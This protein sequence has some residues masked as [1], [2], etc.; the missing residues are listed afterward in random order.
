M[1][2]KQGIKTGLIL[3]LALLLFGSCKEEELY[4]INEFTKLSCNFNDEE[5]PNGQSLTAYSAESLVYDAK[6][7]SVAETR[8]CN[9]GELSG[10]FEFASCVEEPPANCSFDNQ[11]VLHEDYVEAFQLSAVEWNQSCNDY[12]KIRTCDNGTLSEADY[13]FPSCTATEPL[14]CTFESQTVLHGA[15]VEAY[16]LSSVP[17]NE[18]CSS[19]RETRSCENG[20]LSGQGFTFSSCEQVT[21]D[22]CTFE[23]QT[24]LHGA[25]VEAYQLSSVPWNETCSSYRE[26]RSCENGVLS[27]QG[28]AFS[29]CEQVAPDN[30]S[31]NDQ[32]VEHQSSVTAWQ[33]SSVP[34][35][36]SC[37]SQERI[38][39]NGQLSGS[40]TF[41]SCATAAP[42]NCSAADYGQFVQH[43][44]SEQF[45]QTATV[46][47]GSSCQ[48][49][50]RFCNNGTLSGSYTFASCSV[51][52][53]SGC[54][55]SDGG[56]TAH[57]PN[58][59][60]TLYNTASS[61]WPAT[62]EAHVSSSVTCNNGD[63]SPVSLAAYSYQSC[64]NGTPQSCT[65][66]T[67]GGGSSTI[68]HDASATAY[69]AQSV[70]F[71]TD[72]GC[73]SVKVE[74]QC[75]DSDFVNPNDI[76]NVLFSSA[77][78]YDDCSVGLPSGCTLVGLNGATMNFS[79]DQ[80]GETAIPGF[81][82]NLEPFVDDNTVCPASVDLF[83]YNGDLKLADGTLNTVGGYTYGACQ[84]AAPGG[85]SWFGDSSYN[86]GDTVTAYE[87]NNSADGSCSS[88]E[89]RTCNNGTWTGSFAYDNCLQ[90]SIL[91]GAR[92][93]ANSGGLEFTT[94]PLDINGNYYQEK[95]GTY[96]NSNG[97]SVK[98]GISEVQGSISYGGSSY[99]INFS[100]GVSDTVVGNSDTVAVA[101]VIDSSKSMENNDSDGLRYDAVKSLIDVIPFNTYL[102]MTDFDNFE[103]ESPWFFDGLIANVDNKT[104]AKNSIPNYVGGATPL[105]RSMHTTVGAMQTRNRNLVV[106][107][108]DGEDTAGGK[109][110]SQVISKAD[111]IPAEIHNIGLG[112]AINL[113]FKTMPNDADAGGSYRNVQ[114]AANLAELFE[115]LGKTTSIGY[116]KTTG[117]PDGLTLQA[118]E[119]YSVTIT[120]RGISQTVEFV[121]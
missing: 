74:A 46:P 69:S 105:Y 98:I 37:A 101:V 19:Y 38:C 20:V 9:D 51:S 70:V 94:I 2:T 117:V 112:S 54:D 14:D 35:G 67:P 93:N 113:E 109:S 115:N 111:G 29:S 58:A 64:D 57:D 27:G 75:Y 73:D 80:N 43:N 63:F 81:T 103:N 61:D 107:L 1:R 118:G 21:P 17:W 23:S 92:F 25:D 30:C 110:P 60:L 31:F 12:K 90:E 96:D 3:G 84:V 5:I 114:N 82:T 55:F 87:F 15:D 34:H 108:C 28:F 100:G 6:C 102:Q 50:D 22:N 78:Y 72:G 106:T 119:T 8:T 95:Q 104:T 86:H 32:L 53:A 56:S 88:T 52:E 120:I 7:S 13:I 49:Q 4:T 65:L 10:S 116:A 68:A 44:T 47:Y 36:N 97:S 62:C 59:F 76:N 16:Q 33:T 121:R 11:I 71:G 89:T 42:D 18:T 40:Y 48:P 24:I 85:C 91:V 83:C 45:W 77:T 39:T 41:S 99:S 26:T 66:N 79:H